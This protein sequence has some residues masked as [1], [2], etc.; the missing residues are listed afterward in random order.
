MGTLTPAD[1]LIIKITPI[2]DVLDQLIEALGKDL[3]RLRMEQRC[4][5]ATVQHLKSE[6]NPA[7]SYPEYL[8]R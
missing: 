5:I 7:P 1:S 6:T 4:I 3:E 8:H 2:N